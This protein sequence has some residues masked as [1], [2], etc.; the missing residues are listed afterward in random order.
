M[1]VNCT[2]HTIV[3]HDKDNDGVRE[4][5]P[6]GQVPRVE[7][8]EVVVG[9]VDGFNLTKI[10][11]GEVKDLP[12]SEEGKFFVVSRLVKTACPSRDDLIVPS[13][14][15]RDEKGRVVGCNSFSI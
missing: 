5:K 10:T 4:F 14:L 11:F 6:S 12:E 8:V 15:V 7:T 2:P 3:V 1:L 13:G 9:Q